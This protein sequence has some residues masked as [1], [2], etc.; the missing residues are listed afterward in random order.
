MAHM[1][2]NSTGMNAIAYVGETPW[3]ELGQRMTA[4]AS[5]EEWRKQAGLDWEIETSP[6]RFTAKGNEAVMPDRQVLYRSDTNAALS[7]VST[8]YKIVQPSAVMDFFAQ[9]SEIGGFELEVMGALSGG[10]R[11]WGLAK[12]GDGANVI[13]QDEVRPYILLATGY[14]GMMATNAKFTAIRVV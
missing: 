13:G 10:K 7:V 5:I 1:I 12:V 2:D 14:D 3:H 4:G 8:D 11:I 6:V 9:L